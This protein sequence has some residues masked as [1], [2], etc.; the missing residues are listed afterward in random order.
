MKVED[1]INTCVEHDYAWTEGEHEGK[2]GYL[3]GCQRLD[4]VTHF[5]VEAIEAN[6]WPAL[7]KQIIQGKDVHHVS[8][9]VGY[10]SR[11]EN[12][13]K[14]KHGELKDRHAGD[15]KVAK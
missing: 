8:R 10:F 3:I 11:I 6:N 1:F 13:N 4:T 9:I 5:T 14:S 7:E 15:Y 2:K 12:W